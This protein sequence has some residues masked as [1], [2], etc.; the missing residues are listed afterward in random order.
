M[1]SLFDEN[2]YEMDRVDDTLNQ[3]VG[4]QT[5]SVTIDETLNEAVARIEEANLWKTLYST[6]IFPEGSAR[7][8]I[9]IRLNEKL[10]MIALEEIQVLLGMRQIVKASLLDSPMEE[11]QRAS[12]LRLASLDDNQI[13]VLTKLANQVLQRKESSSKQPESYKPSVTTIAKITTNSSIN[14]PSSKNASSNSNAQVQSAQKKARKGQTRSKDVKPLPVPSA[15]ELIASGAV[16]SNTTAVGVGNELGKAIG[17]LIQTVSQG[18]TL[19]VDKNNN[20]DGE[21]VNERF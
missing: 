12:L 5:N 21:D 18:Q 1:S 4:I 20:N 13:S 3:A 2:E 14:M 7:D 8:D 17:N 9:R 19:H 15:S 6:E 11:S 16:K 10:K